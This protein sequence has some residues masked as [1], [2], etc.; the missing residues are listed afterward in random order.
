MFTLFP[1]DLVNAPRQFAERYFNVAGWTE[2][3]SGGHFAAWERPSE[4]LAGVRAAVE[5]GFG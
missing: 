1:K 3:E 4:Y 2:F 5:L